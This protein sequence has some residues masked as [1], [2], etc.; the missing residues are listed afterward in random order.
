M[1]TSA[2]LDVLHT[3]SQNPRFGG[4]ILLSIGL[5]IVVISAMFYLPNLASTRV[6]Y[7]PIYSVRLVNVA[8]NFGP[9]GAEVPRHSPEV[10][11][12]RST[13][14][15]EQPKAR[16]KE[17]P[18]PLPVAKKEDPEKKITEA[19]ERIRSEK[20]A[21][22]L[23]SAIE[24]IRSEK[25]ARQLSSAIERIRRKKEARQLSS[26]I[27]S[28]RTKKEASQP[29][30]AIESTRRE[31]EASQVS[32]AIESLRKETR[33]LSSAIESTR[34]QKEPSHVSS[35]I[36]GL[37]KE[38]RQLSSAIESTRRQKE[39][40]QV[41]SSIE[42]LRKE[43]R[44][45]SSAIEST[46]REKE[47]SQVGSSIEGLRKEARQLSSA[48][49]GLRRL[50]IIGSS[51]AIETG[52]EGTGGASS[53]VMSI[54]FKIYYNLLWQ[55]IRSVWVLSEEALGGKKNLETIIAIRIAKD[56]QIE[57]I[58][59]EKKSGNPYL[60]ESAL[61]AIQKANPLPPLP[62]GIGTDKFDVGVRF[63]PSDL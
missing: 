59:F 16:V 17:K 6:F 7:S 5:H 55:R 54:K 32:L 10:L 13:P 12:S 11:P 37:R 57:E 38:T 8:P 42:G 56:G 60:D 28:T 21:R 58:Q 20:E 4:T 30:S 34:R 27:E 1:K 49:E 46:R 25:E 51:G 22:Q 15:V 3:L 2:N 24:R 45:L 41:G 52:E 9:V 63:T 33:Q 62:S 47:P 18:V 53:A 39:P 43:A 23:S 19:I 50:V 40:S 35:S 14:A 29:S 36:E 48:I 61:R 31:K 44:Q 26:A